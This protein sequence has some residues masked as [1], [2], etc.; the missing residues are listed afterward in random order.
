M[1]WD[2]AFMHITIPLTLNGYLFCKN[3]NPHL[4]CHIEKYL[5]KSF[6]NEFSVE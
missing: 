5:I 3:K 4:T 1:F 6:M 2:I